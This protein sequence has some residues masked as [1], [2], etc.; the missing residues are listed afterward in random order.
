MDATDCSAIYGIYSW[1]KGSPSNWL[2]S[3]A[4][5]YRNCTDGAAYWVKKY[6]NVTLPSNLN[7]AR[8]WDTNAPATYTVKAGSTNSIEPGDI[9]QSD[10]GS[11]GHVGFVT[12]VTK[13][14]SG[15]VTSFTTAELNKDG[16]GNYTAN[17]YN[18]PRN[19]SSKFNRGGGYDWDHYIDVNGADRGLNNEN[20]TGWGG[21]GS[22][23][24]RGDILA[25]GTILYQNQYLGSTN[26]Q[27]ALVFQG[28]SDVVIYNNS[29]IWHVPNSKNSGA[30]RLIM[31]TDGNL[32]LYR[33]NNTVVWHSVTGGHPGAYANLQSDRNLVVRD[34]TTAFWASGTGGQPNLTYFGS[35]R[36]NTGQQLTHNQYLRSPDGRYAML[37]QT[38][39]NGVL[40][41]PGY[42]VLWPSNTSG[43][44]DRLVMQ[45]DGNLVLYAISTPK[46]SSNTFGANGIAVLQSDGN[47]VVYFGGTSAWLQPNWVPPGQI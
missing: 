41:G 10:D 33:P 25:S 32:V 8:Y 42:H 18:A 2:S 30:D 44:G 20:L 14:Q 22:A 27:H 40:Y 11:F 26:V 45:T 7:D 35:D 5:G 16:D 24:Y 6:T 29:D 47:F 38:D 31:Q 3:R 4:Y 43:Q 36:L 23:T 13:N 12:S 9:A 17:T 21:V 37:M 39:G 19:A 46:W 1:C 34:A 15:A 28:D